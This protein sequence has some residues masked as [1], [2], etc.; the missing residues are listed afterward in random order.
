MKKK[1][2]FE[3]ERRQSFIEKTRRVNDV[4]DNHIQLTLQSEAKRRTKVKLNRK[5]PIKNIGRGFDHT[6]KIKVGAQHHINRILN[7]K[8]KF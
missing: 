7:N 5:L 2:E 1:R 8:G 4:P 3:L 6:E